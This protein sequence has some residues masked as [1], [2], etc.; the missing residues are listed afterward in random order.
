MTTLTAPLALGRS[1]VGKKAVMAVT[2]LI[3]FGFVGLHMLG[4]LKVF[5]GREHFNSYAR[6]IRT[7]G[8][9]ALPATTVLWGLRALLFVS[10]I[11]HIT[12]AVMLGKRSVEARGTPYRVKRNPASTIP[13]R[14]MRWGGVALALFIVYHLLH[15]TSGTLHSSFNEHDAYG[16]M[17]NAFDRAHWYIFVIYAAAVIALGMHVFHGFWSM[18]QTFGGGTGR[19]EKPLRNTSKAIATGL[20]LGYLAGP[21]AILAGRVS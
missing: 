6:F 2:G 17:V 12:M 8:E 13:S 10:V 4:N 15:M 5:T 20:V 9:P 19:L 16:N 18:F 11:L 21:A 14:T 3:L 1:T 7:V